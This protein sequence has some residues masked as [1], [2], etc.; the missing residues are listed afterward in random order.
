[1]KR[2]DLTLLV[3]CGGRG[4]RVAG[5]DKPLLNFRGRPIIQHILAAL[6]SVVG[7]VLI[8]AN[9]N[10]S[11]YRN[12]GYPVQS[13]EQP[14]QGPLAALASCASVINT[15]WVFVCPG[16]NPLIQKSIFERLLS[17]CVK[18]ENVFDMLLV[19]DSSR[20]QPLYFLAKVECLPTMQHALG[21]NRAMMSWID[22]L[23][24]LEVSVEGDFPNINSVDDLKCLESEVD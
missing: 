19:R 11:A 15:P 24:V 10:I 23:N 22:T 1:M 17:A 3:L 21:N 18:S 16:D 6:D 14:F 2:S 5:Q 9:R 8:S 20:I 13:D 4:A 12:L 7:E